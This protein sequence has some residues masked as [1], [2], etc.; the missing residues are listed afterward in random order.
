MPS[1]DGTGPNGF[2]PRTGR[3]LGYCAGYNVPG[4]LRGPGRGGFNRGLGFGRNF[5]GRRFDYPF[6]RGDLLNPINPIN[7][8]GINSEI[9]SESK[10]AILNREKEYLESEMENLKTIINNIEKNITQIKKQE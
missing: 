1:G 2:G 8:I 3:A 10:I 9:T 4:Y 6:H 7:N 5:Y